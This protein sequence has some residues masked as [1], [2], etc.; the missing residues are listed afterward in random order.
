MRE[1]EFG[2]S[3]VL[4]TPSSPDREERFN[5]NNFGVFANPLADPGTTVPEPS[6]F[7]LI[8]AS[9]VFLIGKRKERTKIN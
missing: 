3:L 7:V 6:T 5:G 4:N 2:N 1:D 8:L 9:S